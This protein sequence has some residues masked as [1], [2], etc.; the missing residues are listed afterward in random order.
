MSNERV[1]AEMDLAPARSYLATFENF[2]NQHY[3]RL[4]NHV[5]GLV[6]DRVSAEDIVADTLTLMWI[7]WE[8][9]DGPRD[10]TAGFPRM[11]GYAYTTARHKVMEFLRSARRSCSLA[12][13]ELESVLVG[14]S[15][16]VSGIDTAETFRAIR[17]LPD[18]QRQ[19]VG[20]RILGF[21]DREVAEWLGVGEGTVR[22]HLAQARR[23]LLD[24]LGLIGR[25]SG[26]VGTGAGD[27]R[28]C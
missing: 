3:P 17:S 21:D 14:R 20:M 27:R 19:V 18:R 5:G 28:P 8:S 24:H 1:G 26:A 25:A 7:R 15:G 23:K 4:M 16:G 2:Y 12:D 6:G 13:D 10:A 9:L 11:R 22:S